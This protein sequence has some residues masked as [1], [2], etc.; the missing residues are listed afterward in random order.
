MFR[1]DDPKN[2]FEL[3]ARLLYI[4]IGD[5]GQLSA[6]CTLAHFR[7]FNLDDLVNLMQYMTPGRVYERP[8]SG[9]ALLSMND[10]GKEELLRSDPDEADGEDEVEVEECVSS[11]QSARMN[12]AE[13]FDEIEIDYD[14]RV[15]RS[16]L[17]QKQPRLD[18]MK[19]FPWSPRKT[20]LLK[21]MVSDALD[22]ESE[23]N[24]VSRDIWR[25]CLEA[26]KLCFPNFS[27]K[28]AK[29]TGLM[30]GKEVEEEKE[31]GKVK[32]KEGDVTIWEEGDVVQGAS[33]L[34]VSSSSSI[35]P[36]EEET[37]GFLTYVD[38]VGLAEIKG[39]SLALLPVDTH[40]EE[41]NNIDE[42]QM[43]DDP[44][45]DSKDFMP[46]QE[47][48]E[49]QDE[50]G[51]WDLYSMPSTKGEDDDAEGEGEA[52]RDDSFPFNDSVEMMFLAKPVNESQILTVNTS[53]SSVTD[54][55]P[56]ESMFANCRCMLDTSRDMLEDEDDEEEDMG[57]VD[58]LYIPEV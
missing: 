15:T 17:R 16:R 43:D 54:S 57:E 51:E 7:R 29:K 44:R 36:S 58:F 18:G 20:N 32:V 22:P 39:T 6:M 37:Y 1:E 3:D 33:K 55:N 40:V 48:D 53:E 2:R 49:D 8:T 42:D 26:E 13:R 5:K 38:D 21:K 41:G 9:E 31:L 4:A 12:L 23:E 45:D 19:G 35:H 30:K 27:R 14:A 50:I 56:E 46:E 47:D 11:T 28:K 24:V 25:Q 34:E 10:D 52:T